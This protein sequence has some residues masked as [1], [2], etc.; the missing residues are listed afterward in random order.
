MGQVYDCDNLFFNDS[1]SA[2]VSLS[3][4]CLAANSFLC[5]IEMLGL[6]SFHVVAIQFSIDQLQ[7]APSGHL[8]A[9]IFWYYMAE[10]NP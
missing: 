3:E 8:S 7:G 2:I 10:N 4:S 5:G 1:I 9:F 6:S